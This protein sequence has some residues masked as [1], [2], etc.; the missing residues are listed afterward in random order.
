[1]KSTEPTT[2]EV[3]EDN[4]EEFED[5]GVDT[6]LLGAVEL[7]LSDETRSALR[8]FCSQMARA[9]KGAGNAFRELEVHLSDE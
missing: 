5:D 3:V 7:E 9:L 2:D 6:P 1:M 8:R 4:F